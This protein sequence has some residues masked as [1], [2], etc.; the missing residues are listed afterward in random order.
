MANFDPLGLQN[1]WT[2]FNE[3][4]NISL[5]RGYDHTCKSMWRCN[6]VCGL[7]E[8]MTC[9]MFWCLSRPFFLSFSMLEIALRH[10]PQ[11]D[12][13]DLYFTWRAYT[14]GCAFGGFV[15]ATPHLGESNPQNP[16]F[17]GVNKLFQ[18]IGSCIKCIII[19]KNRPTAST[20]T[21][22]LA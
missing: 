4:Q 16:Y 20:P 7:G 8:H 14:Q 6:N 22:Y 1:P 12:F 11:T 19:I 10:C 5:S 17:M 2:D 18:N 13:D 15:V 21:K 9:H 3:T